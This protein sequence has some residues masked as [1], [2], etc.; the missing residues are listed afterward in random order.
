V[1]GD[2]RRRVLASMAGLYTTGNGDQSD[3]LKEDNGKG[4]A[5]SIT[6]AVVAIIITIMVLEMKD[7]GA[8]CLSSCW[9]R[10]MKRALRSVTWRAKAMCARCCVKGEPASRASVLPYSAPI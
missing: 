4:A 1:L 10:G 9:R 3:P 7:E 8:H 5:S 2:S 6:D